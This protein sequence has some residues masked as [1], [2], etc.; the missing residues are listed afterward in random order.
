[1]NEQS[2]YSL[3]SRRI[4]NALLAGALTA[5]V[6]GATGAGALLSDTQVALAQPVDAPVAAPADFTSVSRR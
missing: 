4:R 6:V 5:G 2:K 3:R 1:M